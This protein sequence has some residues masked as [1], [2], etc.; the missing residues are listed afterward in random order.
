V[1][2]V[3]LTVALACVPLLADWIRR[4]PA[5]AP[6]VWMVIGFL[7]VQHSPLK[8]F[9]AVVAWAGMWPG[10]V[11]GLEVSLVDIV[12]L[13][14]YLTLPRQRHWTPFIGLFGFYL[15]AV[16][17][18]AFQANVPLAATFYAWQLLRIF[19]VSVVISRA[20]AADDRVPMALLKGMAMGLF[21]AAIEAAWQRFGLGIV[22]ST[23][24]FA[25]QNSLGLVSHFIV[26]PFFALLLA[27]ARAKL[28]W[29]VSL[30]GAIVAVLTASRATVAVSGLGFVT[31]FMLSAVRKWT[32]QKTRVA[33]IGTVA[34]L[35]IVPLFLS[36]FESRF[37]ANV[38]EAFFATDG[39]REIL[40]NV[41]SMMLN[42]HLLGV[43]PNHYV[44]VANLEGYNARAGLAWTSNRAHVHN[45]YWLV[46][47]ETGYLGLVAF[48]LML[49]RPLMVAFSCG[50]RH[51]HDVRGD[52]LLGLGVSLLMVY[53]HS[54][55]EWIFITFQA[56]YIFA[57]VT[58]LI[59]GL[60]QQLGYF[61]AGARQRAMAR[62]EF[63]TRP[64]RAR[65]SFGK[66][67]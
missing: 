12:L 20:C 27:D 35:A 45:V 39:E 3:L 28:P 60:A 4:N 41:A 62:Q 40:A 55:Y 23:G 54:F 48:V 26:F 6:K 16:L 34:L 47:A 30:A 56:Q 52:L 14:V 29:F 42:D 21:V 25:H 53:L 49:L 63:E 61:S 15:A 1:K 10:Y 18:S 7:I 43:G 24:S 8:L 19:F 9:M 17:L 58:G 13:A 51:R 66:Q 59:A 32:P 64:T 57:A 65:P 44:N 36:S 38:D 67:P 2:W 46:A 5:V 22:Q 37:G 33:L 50:W 11:L 31:L